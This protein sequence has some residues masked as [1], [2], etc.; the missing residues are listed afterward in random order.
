VGGA[1]G[2]CSALAMDADDT[3]VFRRKAPKGVA[4]ARVTVPVDDG[5][6]DDGGESPAALASKLK[7]KARKPKLATVSFGADEADEVR[8]STGGQGC[9]LIGPDGR[10]RRSR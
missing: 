4:R 8:A 9:M 10:A 5:D 3:V 2:A 7:K 1:A 6:G